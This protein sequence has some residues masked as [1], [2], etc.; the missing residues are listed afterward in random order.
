MWEVGVQLS[1]VH[2]PGGWD[3]KFRIFVNDDLPDSVLV[4]LQALLNWCQRDLVV[5]DHV[6]LLKEVQAQVV[7]N[8]EKKLSQT[9]EVKVPHWE[10]CLVFK[11]LE[12][13]LQRWAVVQEADHYLANGWQKWSGGH[14]SL[15]AGSNP[16]AH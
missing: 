7:P 14:N 8:G 15:K 12:V 1:H 2:L 10:A 5:E 11:K 6:V 16:T 3:P 9:E 13:C 4:R